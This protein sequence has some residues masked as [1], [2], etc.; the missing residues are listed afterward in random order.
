[1]GAPQGREA[2]FL[3]NILRKETPPSKPSSF[4]V[5]VGGGQMGQN[6]GD[7]GYCL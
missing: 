2:S 1:M 4:R 7:S 5:E 6:L 3:M